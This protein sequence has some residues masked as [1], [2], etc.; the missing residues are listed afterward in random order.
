MGRREGKTEREKDR[1]DD[2][3]GKKHRGRQRARHGGRDIGKDRR[4]Y[5]KE[6]SRKGKSREDTLERD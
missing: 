1:G 2:I 4:R 5:T 6:E 3:E